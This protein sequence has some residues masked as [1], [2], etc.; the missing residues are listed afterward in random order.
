M[1]SPRLRFPVLV[2]LL[3]VLPALGLRGGASAAV[4]PPTAAEAESVLAAAEADLLALWV[5][6]DRAQWVQSTYITGDT[7][8]IAAAANEAAIAAAMRFAKEAV[9]F[10]AVDLPLPLRRKLDLLK[11]ALTLP[12]P[13]D[14]AKSAELA[15]LAAGLEGAYGR[16]AYCP[17]E[18]RPC[19]DLGELS[20]RI[21][22]SRDP[23]ELAEAWAGWHAIAREMRPDYVRFVELANE[24]ARELGFADAG[25]LWRSKY[26]LP[27]DAFAAEVARLWE[28]VRPLYEQLHCYVR[29]RLVEEYGSGVVPPDGPIPAHLLGNMWA[30]SWGG[31]WDL[32]APAE[33][34]PGIDLTPI[35]RAKG[36]D[37]REMV[38]SGERFFTSLGLDPLPET[39]WERSMFTKPRDRDVVCHASA[40]DIDQVDDLR[41][42]MCIEIN[43]EDFQTI[44]HELGHNYYQ[45][46]YAHQPPLFRDSANDGFHEALGDTVA[47]SVTPKYLRRIGLVE[48]EPGADADLSLLLRMALEKIAFLPFGLLVD[49]WRW[50]VFSGEVG[51]EAYNE[52]WWKLRREIQG[53][54]PPMPRGEQEFDAGAKYHVPANVPYTRYFLAH[55]LQFQ[56]H[57]ALCETAGE[58]GP[59]HRC[60]IHGS[61]AAGTRLEEMMRM[62]I[63]RPWPDALE[64][65]TGTREMDARALLDYFA[66]LSAWLAEQNRDRQCGWR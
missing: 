54:A 41:I 29:A 45:R 21:A 40:W 33:A 52:A 12:A 10:D 56:F 14:P 27:A 34:A 42:K 66:P 30:Q 63:S 31:V 65:L 26:D 20:K 50:Q 25:A 37:E 16:G 22:T 60:T 51:P 8:A 49:Q 24:G 44:H 9:R 19:L 57:R 64:A 62:G 58:T 15:R 47:L 23:A 6:R 7:E 17:G 53:V 13:S 59:L 35:L 39:F 2:A 3:A 5:A 43:E 4:D 48:S 32:L 11:V 61:A 28:Q 55:I 18:G 46:A 36:F 38:R 1:R